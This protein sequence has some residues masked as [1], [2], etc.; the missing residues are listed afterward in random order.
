MKK[1]INIGVNTNDGTAYYRVCQSELD[2]YTHTIELRDINDVKSEVTE[3]FIGQLLNANNI[4][5]KSLSIRSSNNSAE[6]TLL[7]DLDKDISFD[8]EEYGE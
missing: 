4:K 8:I 1:Y 3:K 2:D 6:V 7:I 5:P